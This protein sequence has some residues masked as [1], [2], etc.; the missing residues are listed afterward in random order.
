MIDDIITMQPREIELQQEIA[1]LKDELAQEEKLSSS[2]I[3]A[4]DGEIKNL[5]RMIEILQ[6]AMNHIVEQLGE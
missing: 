3:K 5:R 1:R 4:R 6:S 2:L